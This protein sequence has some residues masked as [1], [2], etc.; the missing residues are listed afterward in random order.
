MSCHIVR[1]ATVGAI[2]EA[3]V[4]KWAAIIGAVAA[5]VATVT[6]AWG[7]FKRMCR[8]NYNG[9]LLRRDYQTMRKYACQFETGIIAV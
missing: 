6:S 3:K 7:I 5:A 4:K 1:L 9:R 8:P 2:K